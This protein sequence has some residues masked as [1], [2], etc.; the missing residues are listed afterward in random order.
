[1]SDS[2]VAFTND[3]DEQRVF[4][5]FNEHAGQQRIETKQRVLNIIRK[6]YPQHHVTVVDAGNC[7]L[8]DFAAAGKATSSHEGDDE[9]FNATRQWKPVGSGV[10]KKTHPGRLQ[11]EFHFARYVTRFNASAQWNTWGLMSS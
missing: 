10:D 8:L 9:M 5:A 7:S 1:M 2:K 3:T 4:D 11:D 6:Q